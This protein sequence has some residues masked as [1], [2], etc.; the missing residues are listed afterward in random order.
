MRLVAATGVV[1]LTAFV[2]LQC[3]DKS[4][5]PQAAKLNEPFVV[6]LGQTRD[7]EGEGFSVTFGRVAAEQR[8]T[9]AERGFWFGHAEIELEMRRTGSAPTILSLPILGG[10]SGTPCDTISVDTLMYRFELLRLDPYPQLGK[11][12]VDNQY[13]ATLRVSV[14]P[15]AAA[16]L[17]GI[18]VTNVPAES[19]VYADYRVKSATIVRDSLELLVDVGACRWHYFRIFMSPAS[20][21]ESYPPQASLYLWLVEG[22]GCLDTTVSLRVSVDLSAI[23]SLY[24]QSYGTVD[25]I[26][27]NFFDAPAAANGAV[28]ATYVPTGAH[29]N[30]P[31]QLSRVGPQRVA[32]GDT[33]S[34]EVVA[35]DPDGTV[36][37]ISVLDL[38]A[39]ASFQE[40]GNGRGRFRFAPDSSQIGDHI[41]TFIAADG[42]LADTLTVMFSVVSKGNHAPVLNPISSK[43]VR[44]GQLLGFD[45]TAYDPDSDAITIKAFNMPPNA[46]LLGG[47]SSAAATFRFDPGYTQAG[48]YAV[49]FVVSD[50]ILADTEIVRITVENVNRKPTVTAEGPPVLIV[51]STASFRV[52]A[53]D[54]DGDSISLT[55]ISVPANASFVDSGSGV[56]L[57]TLTPSPD[58]VGSHAVTF[59]ASDGELAD[60]ELVAFEVLGRLESGLGILPI[61]PQTTTEGDTLTFQVYATSDL[62]VVTDIRMRWRVDPLLNS[63]PINMSFINRGN[64][65]GEFTF[66]PDFT[67]AGD[68]RIVF[69]ASYGTETDSLSVPLTVADGGNHAPVWLPIGAQATFP[70]NVL[71]VALRLTDPDER[72][73][74]PQSEISSPDLPSGAILT[75]Y[76][77][78]ITF[79]PSSGQTGV[80][81]VTLLAADHVDPQ[82]VSTSQFPIYVHNLRTT[83]GDLIPLAIGSYW[84]YETV[85]Y[86]LR[87]YPGPVGRSYVQSV[88]T[89]DSVEV[90]GQQQIGT[91]M[92]WLFSREL[93]PVGDRIIVRNDSVFSRYGLEYIRNDN[94]T[95]GAYRQVRRYATGIAVPAGGFQ[96][97]YLYTYDAIPYPSDADNRAISI[98]PG[99]GIA[100]ATSS[101]EPVTP[102]RCDY[103]ICSWNYRTQK[104]IRYHL[105]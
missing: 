85:D 56:G 45:V 4:T 100:Q 52:K 95:Y 102:T 1:L 98:V 101:Q 78:K 105:Q 30:H 59:V 82:L 22:R 65:S 14:T 38:P 60:S 51:D 55:A 81:E 88:A 34:V 20:F 24:N 71:E 6:V 93:W 74:S 23:A 94:A 54:P 5:G 70:G 15:L 103:Q 47:T 58:Q 99:I 46:E 8:V 76:N 2:L 28:A 77:N 67:Q 68:Y 35:T 17:E 104:L 7:I 79:N 96:S 21:T 11:Q 19:L 63:N 69:S 73:T 25:P 91:E 13:R 12:A 39:H 33:C 83:S 16:V 32:I 43:S 97:Y 66:M 49:L 89:I 72:E 10:A 36:P 87:W 18:T 37:T 84:V 64:G 57:F 80:Y 44:E 86:S 53:I 27:L 29:L 50:G 90:I 26:M 92:W 9:V 62:G 48:N 31:P 41:V 75:N 61:S 40:I 3:S 42:T